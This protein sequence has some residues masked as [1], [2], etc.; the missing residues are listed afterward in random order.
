[1]KNNIQITDNCYKFKFSLAGNKLD[2]HTI[3]KTQFSL[4]SLSK[5]QINWFGKQRN[6]DSLVLIVYI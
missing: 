3:S 6:L 5:I 4:E 2:F 1:M